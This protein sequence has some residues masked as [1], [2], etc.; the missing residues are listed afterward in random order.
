[1]AH[2]RFIN[3]KMELVDSPAYYNKA[4]SENMNLL[5]SWSRR[6]NSILQKREADLEENGITE[7]EDQVAH[8]LNSHYRLARLARQ[9]R[10]YYFGMSIMLILVNM[11]LLTTLVA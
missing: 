1:M 8:L 6:W 5:K 4:S 7:A 2:S 3:G 10:N 9:K 11:I